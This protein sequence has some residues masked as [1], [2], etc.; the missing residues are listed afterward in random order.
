MGLSLGGGS[1][2][3]TSSSTTSGTYSPAQSGLQNQLGSTLSTDLAAANAGVLTPG[4]TAALTAK[5]DA[6]NKTSNGLTGRIT[7]FLAQRGFG[8][9]GQTGEAN[10]QGE[11]GR[12]SQVGSNTASAYA[13][14]GNQNSSNL[15]AALNY[16]FTSLG[17]SSD[18]AQQGSGF[19]WG[20]SVSG[21]GAAGPNGMAGALMA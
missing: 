13:D 3:G 2:Q 12:E 11:L 6:T 14:Q 18:G 5:N 1:S 8:A 20:A 16:A 15:L 9:S 17:S 10:L 4:N 21:A 7:N 19:N